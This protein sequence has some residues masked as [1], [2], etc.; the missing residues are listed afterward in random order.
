MK[1]NNILI[2]A[3]LCS[4]FGCKSYED[5]DIHFKTQEFLNVFDSKI[6]FCI[7]GK[8]E[9]KYFVKLS[10][11]DVLIDTMSILSTLDQSFKEFNFKLSN[12]NE[13]LPIMAYKLL[14]DSEIKLK[15]SATNLENKIYLD[16]VITVNVRIPPICAIS[17]VTGNNFANASLNNVLEFKQKIRSYFSAGRESDIDKAAI[18]ADMLISNS[19]HPTVTIQDLILPVLKTTDKIKV[20]ILVDTVFDYSFIWRYPSI[21]N[22]V[23]SDIDIEKAITDALN[24][25]ENKLQ[26]EWH[27]EMEGESYVLEDDFQ[28]SLVGLIGIFVVNVDNSGSF[29]YHE[30]GN[31]LVDESPPSFNES[32]WC[33]FSGDPRYEG[34]LCLSTESFYG[35][36]PYSVPF[37]G[38]VHGDVA[39]IYV[40]GK[41]IPFSGDK[42]LYFKKSI[43]LDGGY[44]RVKVKVVDIKGN[45][46]EYF[47][48]ITIESLEEN[49]IN[50]EN[51][52]N[53]EN[54]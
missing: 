21:E 45:S 32:N 38:T 2:V 49:N 10:Y 51:E 20:R 22:K 44:N 9:V 31:F 47:I 41:R 48:P 15:L 1:L 54:R 35:Y 8:E 3:C 19:C 13:E 11:N 4:M 36:N 50:I 52:I 43:Y 17:K 25:Q 37:L 28:A 16:T 40:D 46:A 42:E 12:L 24:N 23:Y 26:S 18:L 6:N 53:I 30:F 34:L 5:H 27:G 33:S 14:L 39:E 7:S 29:T